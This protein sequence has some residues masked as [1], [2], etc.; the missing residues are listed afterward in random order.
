MVLKQGICHQI[1]LGIG[2]KVWAFG[3]SQYV[4]AAVRNIETHLESLG[5]SLHQTQQHTLIQMLYR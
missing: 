2:V 5:K 3:S 1:M 4:Q